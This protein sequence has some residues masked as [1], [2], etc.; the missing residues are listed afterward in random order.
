[1]EN[2]IKDHAVKAYKTIKNPNLKFWHKVGEI[3]IEVGIIVFAVT[4]SIWVHDRSE[5]NHEQKM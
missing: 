3:G 2:E 4:L 1:M 5:Y